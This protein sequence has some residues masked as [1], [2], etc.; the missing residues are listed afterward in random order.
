[1][2]NEYTLK[3]IK[4]IVFTK[5]LALTP[6]LT[7]L[8]NT[9]EESVILGIGV[10]I[11]SMCDYVFNKNMTAMYNDIHITTATEQGLQRKLEDEGLTWGQALPSSVTLRIGS[12]NVPTT[13]IEI[14]QLMKVKTAD[15]NPVVFKVLTSGAEITPSTPEDSEG[16]YT[17]EVE[18]EA[19]EGGADTNVSAMTINTFDTIINGLNVVYNEDSATG[20]I[21]RESIES[22]RTRLLTKQVVFDRGTKSWFVSEAT[23]Y[24]YV[25][26][27]YVIPSSNGNGS[28]T[29]RVA[30]FANL[31]SDQ[32]NELQAHFDDESVNDAGAYN[33]TIEEI[34]TT[35][36]DVTITIQRLDVSVTQ[37]DIEDRISKYF[38][39]EL[40]IG[41]DFVIR[42]FASYLFQYDLT[43]IYDVIIS[44]PASN[45]VIDD[46][47]IAI[48]GTVNVTM[49][50]VTD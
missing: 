46:G 4:Q 13:T 28:V 19:T 44:S 39:Q 12:E 36:V 7:R 14:P 32:I 26:D 47:E 5:A 25:K 37:S 40:Q 38:N 15:D 17:V 33:V 43:N 22:V 30:G 21:D 34:I 41:D 8:S 49:E 23:E 20:G 31:T 18:A 45:I 10:G 42:K 9:S 48:E 3:E 27:A 16:Y 2:F 6:E 1:M 29:L 50:D 11:S 35:S 24:S